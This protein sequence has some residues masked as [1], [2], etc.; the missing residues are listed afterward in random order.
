VR[1]IVANYGKT[2]LQVVPRDEAKPEV[3]LT[4]VGEVAA[5]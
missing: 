5:L 2:Y 3:Q 1:K 4:Q